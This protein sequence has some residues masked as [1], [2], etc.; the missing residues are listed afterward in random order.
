MAP[1]GAY[2][3]LALECRRCEAVVAQDWTTV[4]E[5]MAPELVY[6]HATGTVHDRAACLAYLREQVRFAV[7]LRDGLEVHVHGDVAWMSGL[8]RLAGQRL[9]SGELIA[10]ISFASQVWRRAGDSWQLALFQST[11]VADAA[12]PLG[13]DSRS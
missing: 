6:V 12:W 13:A 4:A 9:P 5:L 7:V 8:L 1:T 3:I 11:K 2:P 10:A